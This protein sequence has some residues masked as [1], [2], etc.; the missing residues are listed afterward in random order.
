MPGLI[1]REMEVQVLHGALRRCGT[2][3]LTSKRP[4][5]QAG[6]E[7]ASPSRCASPCDW[8]RSFNE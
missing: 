6:N 5:C 1:N 2:G 3:L 7:G 8:H 4:V